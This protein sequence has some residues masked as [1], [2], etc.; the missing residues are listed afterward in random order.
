M[1]T[2]F[3]TIF[4]KISIINYL[5]TIYR[6]LNIFSD[7]PLYTGAESSENDTDG[8]KWKWANGRLPIDLMMWV[9]NYVIPFNGTFKRSII[10]RG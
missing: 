3:C 5:W 4:L 6:T 2:L 10:L 8:T 9:N 7:M 1:H